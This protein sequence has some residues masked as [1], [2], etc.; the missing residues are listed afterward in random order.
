MRKEVF[1]VIGVGF[2]PANLALAIAFEELAPGLSVRFL[3]ACSDPVWQGEMLLDGANIQNNPIRDLV[4]LRN[5]RSRYTFINYLFEEG[6]LLQHL[7]LPLQFPLRKEYA[8]Y[9][10]WATRQFSA[11]VELGA[12]VTGIDIDIDTAS[13][14]NLYVLTTAAGGS[15]RAR[16]VSLATGRT[17]Y[18]PAPFA[19]FDHP[20][21][22]HSHYYRSSLE[23]L[24]RKPRRAVVVGASQSAVEITLDLAQ[25]YPETEIVLLSKA[26]SLA[27]KDTSP[28]SEEG[29]F[30]EFVDYYHR[31]SRA[32]KREM[33]VYFRRTNYS[34]VDHDLLDKLYLYLYEQ[35]LDGSTR[36]SVRQR[37]EVTE[38]KRRHQDVIRLQTKEIYTKAVDTYDADLVIVATGYRDLGPIARQE[39]YPPLLP[40]VIDRFATDEDGYLVVNRD[41]SLEP[42]QSGTPP[43]VLNGLCES[44]HGIGDAGSFSL[45]S[46][47]AE[48]ILKGLR[49][50]LFMSN[51]VQ[52]CASSA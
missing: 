16:A 51:V 13:E 47:R 9:V 32:D 35:S 15:F 25:R 10:Q 31:A 11:W 36:V 27:L 46:L 28:F 30:P 39:P 8:R 29:Y 34:C 41:Y 52:R 22:C 37:T 3:E 48:M 44:T 18:L 5:P 24:T 20:A 43:M 38:L 21:V 4:T 1:D 17:P 14:E 26:P 33:D 7:N 49:E 23:R 6:R 12:K 50:K 2:G 42:R 19:G 40:R 45:L